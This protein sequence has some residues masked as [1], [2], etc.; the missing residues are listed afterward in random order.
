M[1]Y[2]CCAPFTP[3]KWCFDFLDITRGTN[4]FYHLQLLESDSSA[5]WYVWRKWGRVGTGKLKIQFPLYLSLCVYVC[6]YVVC[7]L[8]S[9]AGKWG[10]V[11]AACVCPCVLWACACA[12]A[13]EIFCLCACL[14]LPVRVLLPLRDS[15]SRHTYTSSRAHKAHAFL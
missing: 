15:H 13:Y 12:D 14:H 9:S 10:H 1:W 2:S 5:V 7:L 8:A 3:I 4:S 6:M 11:V